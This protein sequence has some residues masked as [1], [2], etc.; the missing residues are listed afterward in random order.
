[1]TLMLVSTYYLDLYLVPT[2]YLDISSSV[3]GL[4]LFLSSHGQSS[5]SYLL[6]L[7]ML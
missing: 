1:M 6:T 2:L 4:N 5:S 3:I 7:G